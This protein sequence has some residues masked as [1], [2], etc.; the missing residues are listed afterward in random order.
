MRFDMTFLWVGWGAFAPDRLFG[1]VARLDAPFLKIFLAAHVGL[2]N[3]ARPK[4]EPAH[5]PPET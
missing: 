1:R 4:R 2:A 3:L 5:Y